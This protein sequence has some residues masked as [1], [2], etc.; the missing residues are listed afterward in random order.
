[1]RNY[2]IISFLLFFFSVLMLG[3]TEEVL[4][5]L[6]TIL[7]VG[8]G[9][10]RMKEKVDILF[11]EKRKEM[12]KSYILIFFVRWSKLRKILKILYNLKNLFKLLMVNLIFLENKI[13]EITKKEQQNKCGWIFI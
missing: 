13:K 9:I 7:L 3:V 4:L 5:Y 11:A 8:L 1:M 10:H 12:E 2:L 6:G